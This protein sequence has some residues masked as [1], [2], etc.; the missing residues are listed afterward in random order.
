MEYTPSSQYWI[1]HVEYRLIIC[2][3]C[4]SS[5]L[6]VSAQRHFNRYHTSIPSTIRKEIVAA[7][8]AV[9]NTVK[10]IEQLQHIQAGPIVAIPQLPLHRDGLRCVLE[11]CQYICRT[12]QGMDKHWREHVTLGESTTV[13][14]TRWTDGV[15]CQQLFKRGTKQQV[16]FLEVIA[17]EVEVEIPSLND[18]VA[19]QTL[20]EQR[21][22]AER[23]VLD[24]RIVGVNAR[25]HDVDSWMKM[26]GW[27]GHH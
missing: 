27:R 16:R 3:S 1:L 25:Y 7:I 12:E 6:A 10:D 17:L 21:Q 24:G 22:L 8:I 13:P 9:P 11:R 2:T 19:L 18:Q 20:R 14:R 5:I 23:S 15:T 26:N 4:R